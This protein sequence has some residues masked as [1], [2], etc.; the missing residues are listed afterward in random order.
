LTQFKLLLH[1]SLATNKDSN[2]A[3][4]KILNDLAIKMPQDLDEIAALGLVTADIKG[5]SAALCY[6]ACNGS[7]APLDARDGIGF[8]IMLQHH[9]VRLYEAYNS[10][11]NDSTQDRATRWVGQ[12]N[13]TQPW[14]PHSPKGDVELSDSLVMQNEVEKNYKYNSG[15]DD[16]DA[17]MD[18]LEDKKD[19]DLVMRQTASN[20]QGADLMVLSRKHGDV[21]LHLFQCKNWNMF[22][23]VKSEEFEESLWSLGVKVDEEGINSMPGSGSAGY[24]Y[25][26]TQH[27]AKKLGEELGTEVKIG[28]RVLVI[29]LEGTVEGKRALDRDFLQK[30]MDKGVMVWT[31]EML[32]PTI[33]ALYHKKVGGHARRDAMK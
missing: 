16:I 1:A 23:G 21:V 12:C 7:T 4:V 27:F 5:T 15:D 20:A 30:A 32:E 8:E 2:P 6:L 18:L 24:S 9:L 14:P 22:P 10:N 29:S 17:I 13:L 28:D 33:S 11:P 31:K 26:G 19:F 3:S 25:L